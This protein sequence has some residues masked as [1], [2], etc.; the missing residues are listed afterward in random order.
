MLGLALTSVSAC[1]GCS[2]ATQ[3]SGAES[4][5]HGTAGDEVLE[6]AGMMFVPAGPFWRGCDANADDWCSTEAKGSV[7]YNVPYRELDLSAFWIDKYEVTIE[8]YRACMDAG[9]CSSTD[10]TFSDDVDP[11]EVPN[12][13]VT[14]ANW[15]SAEAYCEWADKRL[16]TEAE[17][18]KAARG[19]DGRRWPWGDAWPECEQAHLLISENC[20]TRHVLRV[21]EHPGDVS[22]YGVVGMIGN[23]QEWVSDWAASAYY[24]SAPRIDPMGPDR[25]GAYRDTYKVVRGGYFDAGPGEPGNSLL[26]VYLRRWGDWE[27]GYGRIGFRCARSNAP[28]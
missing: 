24:E 23:V 11:P 14:G 19:T 18:E 3:G 20:R 28:P 7:L 4:N 5:A 27:Q 2:D 25:E 16:P 26:S 10:G 6:V 8:Q 21:D 1:G 15:K 22:P 9:A 12:L 13:P 17:W